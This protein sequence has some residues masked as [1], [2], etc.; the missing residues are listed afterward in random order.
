MRI[1]AC[2]LVLFVAGPALAQ[3]KLT[4]DFR[5]AKFDPARL[6]YGGPTPDK[7]LKLEAEG[8]R[9]RYTGADAPP[10]NNPSCVT[11]RPHVR[12]DFVAT[13]RYEILK[14]EP[15]AKGTFLAGAE[16]YVRLDN[17]N[18][19]AVMVARGVFPDGSAAINFKVLTNDVKGKRLTT[20]FK[21]LDTTDKSLRGRLRLVRNGPII[22]GFFAEGEVEQ[23]TEVQHADVGTADIRLVRFAGIAG[24]DAS[25]VLDMRIL[26]LELEGEEL[27]LDGQFAKPLAKAEI[28]KAKADVPKAN[29]DAPQPVKENLA[30]PPPEQEPKNKSNVFPLAVGLSLLVIAVLVIVCIVFLSRR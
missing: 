17:P 16:L 12:G 11:W 4:H 28:P 20:D 2:V 7:F 19:D 25:V 9:L 21:R 18:S 6:R 27:A 26:E 30:P 22:T 23:F 15:P 10:T 8:L 5:G 29:A 14:S 3:Q 1:P 13:A 24:G